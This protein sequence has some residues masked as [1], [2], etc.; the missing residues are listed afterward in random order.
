MSAEWIERVT[1]LKVIWGSQAFGTADD[2]SDT[3]IRGVCIP[4]RRYILG[5]GN[6]EQY[7]ERASDTVIYSLAKF[8]TL[9]QANN[10]NILDILWAAEEDI[11]YIDSFG[12]QLRGARDLFLSRQVA[13][14]YAG[15]AASQIRRME[16]H[17]RWLHN[18]PDHQPKPADFGAQPH[19]EGG[20]R[21]S[22][23]HQER[24]FRGANKHWQNYQKWRENRNPERGALEEIHG[25]DTK[26][27]LHLLRLY[28][29]GI[30][31]L[32]EGVV[33]VKR[34]DAEWLRSVKAGRYTYPELLEIVED[35]QAE[36]AEAERHT[37]LPATPDEAAIDALLVDLH[38]Q[39]LQSER[40]R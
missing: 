24:A 10:P 9:A 28:R 11:R 29:M 25:Y 39:A 37:S 20:V 34:P 7:E 32:R 2:E 38:W 22:N 13:Q 40:F 18:P 36:L 35:L 14:T 21:F 5:L 15:Y 19:P 23:T 31:I 26:H 27:A 1:I 30:E 4:P 6:F 33:R 16:T 17:Y 12:A 3:D 8:V